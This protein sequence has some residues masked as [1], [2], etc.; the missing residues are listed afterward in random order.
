MPE[1]IER[2]LREVPPLAAR[3]RVSRRRFASIFKVILALISAPKY[4]QHCYAREINLHKPGKR[5]PW[6]STPKPDCDRSVISR[7]AVRRRKILESEDYSLQRFHVGNFT[8]R[9]RLQF[10]Q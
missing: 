8:N 1:S 10:C 6:L 4:V 7:L 2:L 9:R 3:T 5:R